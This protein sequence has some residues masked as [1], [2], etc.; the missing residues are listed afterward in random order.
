[1]LGDRLLGSLGRKPWLATEYYPLG[2]ETVKCAT[3]ILIPFKVHSR[4]VARRRL[5]VVQILTHFGSR[6]PSSEAEIASYDTSNDYGTWRFVK[7][8]I[9]MNGRQGIP[10]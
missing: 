6:E 10:A 1:M 9:R 3:S 8:H 5:M 2:S 7:H 4:T